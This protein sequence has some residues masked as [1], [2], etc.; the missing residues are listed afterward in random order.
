[1][2]CGPSCLRMIAKH[3]G[4][5]FTL[6]TLRKRSHI[7]RE[8]VS[9]MGINEAAESIH[10]KTMAV[11]IGFEQLKK[12]VPLPC[13][14]HWNQ[15]HFIVVYKIKNDKVYIADPAEGLIELPTKD[16][17]KGFMS[18]AKE[19][20]DE[21]ICLLLEPKA[22]FYKAD[23]EKVDKKT[24]TFLLQYLRSY[25]GL[26]VQLFIGLMVGSL[27]QLI[28][29]FLTQSVVDFGINN[30][31]FNFVVLILIAQLVLF[32]SQTTVDAIRSWILLHI[33][34]RVNISLISD[35]LS[36]LMRL[37][38]SYFDTKIVG[39]IMQ[40]INDHYRIERFLTA[41]TIGILF[42]F[43]NLIIFG[44][45]LI[46]YSFK[47]FFI[48]TV[49][50]LL[51]AAWVLFF[52]KKRK[53][54]DYKK[55]DQSSANQ[56]KIIQLIQGM[57]EIKLNNSE[58]QKRWEWERIQAKVFKLNVDTLQLSQI[59]ELGGTFINQLKNILISF[60]TAKLV[61]DGQLT[62]GM[63]MSVQYI[64]G[65]LSSP[66]N[67]L[68][69]FAQLMQ[70]AKI[71]LE[72]LGEI[73]D[74]ENEENPEDDKLQ[75]LP[76]KRDIYVNDV[77]FQYGGP[78]S[79]KVLDKI[80][81]T[82][83]EG[84][85]TAI[86]GTS[87]SGKTTLIKLLMK[88]YEPKKGEVK[89]GETPINNISIKT[90]RNHLGAVMQDGFIFSDT[91]ANNIA[92]GVEKIDKEQLLK[93][94]KTANIQQFIDS[95]PLGFNTKIG[96]DGNGLSQGQKQ[97]ILIA[98][99]VYKNP[100]FM[101][102]DEATNALDANN[103]RIIMENLD[104]FFKGKTVVIVAHRL[105]TVKNADKIIVLEKGCLVEEGTHAQLVE[106]KGAYYTLVKNQLELGN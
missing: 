62:L 3:Y 49:G 71:S 47:I 66:I 29:P 106:N 64:I 86:V 12:E 16:F 84:K 69:N 52:M 31:N 93:A 15:N 87:G 39:D 4:K 28:F 41:S 46:V 101:F 23:D 26:L 78:S 100:S 11:S 58:T 6:D 73:H 95:L 90:W 75:E 30:Q 17:L 61:I 38:I 14:A 68:L 7:D 97:R 8:G 20:K 42:S 35:F 81:T 44:I 88:F 54:L 74:K 65:Q 24:W 80:K 98:R 89:I 53:N 27:L 18:K 92:V 67:Q 79:E 57:Q 56:S 43:F 96:A 25:K 37:P 59:Q 91:I 45:V 76:F 1:M 82:I 55:F 51:Y 10:F 34:S 48:F 2:D 9:L 13:I 72:R 50:S 103:E 21:G 22:E 85:I 60:Y 40:R 70:D 77:E 63:M 105:S 104:E 94:T 36:K 99:A 19:G 83:P 32:F 33:S 102:F 5:N